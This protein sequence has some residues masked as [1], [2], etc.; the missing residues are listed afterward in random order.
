MKHLFTYLFFLIHVTHYGQQIS[1]S[2]MHDN[3]QRD[4]ILYVPSSYDP[5][6][7]MPLVFGFHGYTSNALVN[8]T[9]T[10]LKNIADTAGFI[11]VH[12]QGSLNSIG[13]THWNVGLPGS[14]SV[15]DVGFTNA[16]MDTLISQYNIDQSR[17][18][19]CG[20]SNGGYMSFLLG[21]QLSHRVA[22]IASITGSMTLSTFN[23]CNPQRPVP[24]LQIHGTQDS[25]V[26]YNG[27]VTWSKSIDDVIQ[28][29][30]NFNNCN[31][32][33]TVTNLPDLVSTDGSTVIHYEYSG[34]NNGS[35]VAHF[36][37]IDGGHDWPGVWGNLDIDASIEIWRFFSRFNIY[38][39]ISTSTL[40]ME[41]DVFTLYPR[42]CDNQII[43]ISDKKETYA[44]YDLNGKHIVHG[45]L[46]NGENIISVQPYAKG[47]YIMVTNH[48]REKF[49]VQ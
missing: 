5:T 23:N 30:V 12:P 15:D 17:I 27:N 43:V 1:T 18:Y 45:V 44:I 4:Y 9:Y 6:V 47:T 37:V 20:M 19:A 25:T 14:S 32:T 2:I 41:K 16:L 10:R 39:P 34:G 3:M 48:H 36:K 26:P 49:L 7:S 29:W 13:N 31:A 33:P 42:I 35:E 21:C 46:K 11:V 38:G 8:L 22:A 40:Q 24:V 28:Y